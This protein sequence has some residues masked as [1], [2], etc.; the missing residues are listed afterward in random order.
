MT[1]T[2]ALVLAA[3]LGLASCGGWSNSRL[4]PG[5]WFGRSEPVPVNTDPTAANPLLPQRSKL[6]GRKPEADYHVPIQS[7]SDL[8]VERTS[9]GAIIR[10]TGQAA[11]QGAYE[12]RLVPVPESEDTSGVLTL[13]FEVVYPVNPRPAGSDLTR[14]IIAAYSVTHQDLAKVRTIRVVAET[15]ARETRRR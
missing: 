8:V 10:A 3:S 13:T 15:N 4:N 1:R 14:R 5:N 6:L 2:L 12:P 7:V 11:K 9:S